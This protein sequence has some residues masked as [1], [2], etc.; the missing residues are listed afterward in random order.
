MAKILLANFDEEAGVRLTAF[1][2]NERYEVRPAFEDES[3]SQ[4]LRRCGPATDLLILDVSRREKYARD[5]LA[6][7]TA[8]RLQH[9][10][11]PMLLCVLRAYRG[12]QFELDL[13]RKGARVV[14]VR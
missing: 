14:Y 4:M 13:E 8:Y 11:R 5:L 7:I 6:Q 1:F 12:A 3:L 2:R 10:P 9:G